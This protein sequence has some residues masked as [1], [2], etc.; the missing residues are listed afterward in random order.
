MSEPRSQQSSANPRRPRNGL[1]DTRRGGQSLN[2]RRSGRGGG[3][4]SSQDV[5][6]PDGQ[7][8]VDYDNWAPTSQLDNASAN[9]VDPVRDRAEA[10]LAPRNT[11]RP[12]RP[13][14]KNNYEA[15]PQSHHQREMLESLPNLLSQLQPFELNSN[16]V[17]AEHQTQLNAAAVPFRPGTVSSNQSPV[18]RQRHND[19]ERSS[20]NVR[21]QPSSRGTEFGPRNDRTE[22]A[23]RAERT[24]RPR[25]EYRSPRKQ[26]PIVEAEGDPDSQ[27]N[28]F[29]EQLTSGDYECMVCCDEVKSRHEI[30][31]CANCY[32]IFHLKCINLWAHSN[33]GEM[34]PD[35]ERGWRCPACQHVHPKIPDRY[36]CFCG[37]RRD[38]N[39]RNHHR[40][41]VPHSCGE[42]CGKYKLPVDSTTRCPHKCELVCHPGEFLISCDLKGNLLIGDF[43]RRSLSSVHCQS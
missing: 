23:P 14:P 10:G 35:Q 24:E 7:R 28:R 37:S 20:R 18:H 19:Y 13:P 21:S 16:P 17:S 38:P 1:N 25:P 15:R 34:G 11:R 30:W 22:F 12:R 33:I 4:R 6:E 43:P 40:D 29:I 9:Y 5:G 2:G 31:N 27:R 36:Y 3:G 39:Y 26:K 32:H 8:H 41:L 42:I